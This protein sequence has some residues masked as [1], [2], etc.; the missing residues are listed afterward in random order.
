MPTLKIAALQTDIIWEKPGI[1]QKKIENLLENAG[2]NDLVLLPEFFN[3][4]FSVQNPKI[5]EQMKG[6]TLK[7][8]VRM[9]SRNRCTLGGSLLILEGKRLY[10]RAVYVNTTGV[11]GFY[12][13]RHLFG[14]GGETARLSS[15][16]TNTIIEVKG[17]KIKPQI[18]YDLR[19]PVWSRNRVEDK[20]FEYDILVYHANWPEARNYPWRQLLIARAIENQAWVVGINRCGTDGNGFKYSGST[21]IIDYMGN[22]VAEADENNTGLIQASFNLESLKD[23]RTRFPVSHDWDSFKIKV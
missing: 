6:L 17:F 8:M 9:A 12:D 1:N 4:G 13:K 3:T 7:W 18:C 10:N 5:A 23:F 20:Q 19:F 22:I 15:G 16:K 21:M 2:S 11:A 14:L